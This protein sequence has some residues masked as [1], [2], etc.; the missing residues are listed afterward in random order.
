M[1]KHLLGIL[2][3]F[4]TF[5][6][7][8]WLAPIKF[9]SFA[10]GSGLHGSFTAFESTDFVKL[11]VTKEKYGNVTEANKSFEEHKKE[12]EEFIFEGKVIAAVHRKILTS[13]QNRV[14]TF[15]QPKDG[16]KIYCSIRKN[17]NLIFEICSISDWHILEF[18]KQYFTE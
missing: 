17:E 2:I 10:V 12:Y 4:I 14:F 11:T 9:T 7:G 13:E 1:K 3:L 5:G 8:F 16:D 18:E 6:I 15:N